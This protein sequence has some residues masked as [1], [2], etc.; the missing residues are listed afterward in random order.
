MATGGSPLA[1]LQVLTVYVAHDIQ[2]QEEDPLVVDYLAADP[3][4]RE[5]GL[6][7]GACQKALEDIGFD[8][9]R[10]SLT[11]STLSGAPE[12]LHPDCCTP[13]AA[14]QMLHQNTLA[15]E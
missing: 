13:N 11:I 9:S 12:V 14:P 3:L 8:E 4:I 2:S 6:D 7:K 10:L 15:G 5:K 1:W